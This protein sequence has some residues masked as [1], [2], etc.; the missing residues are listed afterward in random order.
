[1]YLNWCINCV[2]LFNILQATHIQNR[3]YFGTTPPQKNRK[4]TTKVTF[5][6]PSWRSLNLPKG[7]LNHPKKVTKNCQVHVITC[8]HGK[9]LVVSTSK[10]DCF[11][12]QK[13]FQKPKK[14]AVQTYS[15]N[16]VRIWPSHQPKC[17]N[18]CDKSSGLRSKLRLTKNSLSH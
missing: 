12:N 14:A 18:I 7:S 11:S 13:S 17:T 16:P 8:I 2:G 4:N 10:K 3:S 1:M 5:L 6:S 15:F 9:L